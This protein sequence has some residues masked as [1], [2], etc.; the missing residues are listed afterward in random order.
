MYDFIDIIVFQ[1]TRI[2]TG[3]RD[4]NFTHDIQLHYQPFVNVQCSPNYTKN[5]TIKSYD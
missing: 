3:E 2:V 1:V 4:L 5:I